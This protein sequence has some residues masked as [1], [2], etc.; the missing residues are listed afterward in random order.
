[1]CFGCNYSSAFVRILMWVEH[2][3]E[4]LFYLVLYVHV[5]IYCSYASFY[6]DVLHCAY[7]RLL[8]VT[9]LDCFV[10]AYHIFKIF[11]WCLVL[12]LFTI[13]R[14]N[15][16][17]INPWWWRHRQTL[18]HWAPTLHWHGWS[19]QKASSG[20][21]ISENNVTWYRIDFLCSIGGKR[22][23]RKG[24]QHE[25]SGT[26]QEEDKTNNDPSPHSVVAPG[27]S[28]HQDLKTPMKYPS[29]V[30]ILEGKYFHNGMQW[31]NWVMNDNLYRI[32][33]F[34][35]VSI[36]I[37]CLKYYYKVQELVYVL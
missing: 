9:T 33:V 14:A 32:F 15:A 6:V 4:S 3:Y 35:N 31:I 19:P 25:V 20:S 23:Q 10:L 1:M 8:Y 16:D 30:N 37:Y 21:I 2:L 26:S 12:L 34:C 18:E 29:N 13:W 36:A 28:I 11:S 22:T 27:S 7:H 24:A 5:S 17:H